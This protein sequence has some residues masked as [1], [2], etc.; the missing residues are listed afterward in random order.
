MLDSPLT[1]VG[2][3]GFGDSYRKFRPNEYL[4]SQ[5]LTTADSAHNVPLD[6]GSSGGLPLFILY[7]LILF[8]TIYSIF[9]FVKR[10]SK[11]DPV[12]G[13]LCAAWFAYQTQSFLSINQIGL[14]MWGWVLTG[15]LVGYEVNSRPKNQIIYKTK[16]QS[17]KGSNGL[18]LL[19]IGGT[20]GA[21]LTLP[22]YLAADRY[23]KALQS[24]NVEL[25][26]KTTYQKPYDR[27]RFLY[28]A[29]I[30][31]SNNLEFRAI[32][33]LKDASILYPDNYEVWLQWSRV[34]GVT[35]EQ[36]AKAEKELKRL[37]TN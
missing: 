36:K 18:F 31:A 23:Y 7:L 17:K 25:L 1:G 16:M 32:Q 29:Q 10:S 19:L 12:H 22:P 5:F 28:S 27:N 24:G 3:D 33:I 8:Y 13:S 30:L 34:V 20:L 6:L 9:Q 14:A 15:L 11:F 21:L 35:A 26:E 2:F 4:E 37:E